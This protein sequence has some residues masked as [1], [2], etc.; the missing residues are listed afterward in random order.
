MGA[1]HDSTKTEGVNQEEGMVQTRR[2]SRSMA[3]LG[4]RRASV[5]V[6][7]VGSGVGDP[8]LVV[9]EG[10]AMTGDWSHLSRGDSDWLLA[11]IEPHVS[12]AIRASL[13]GLSTEALS[14]PSRPLTVR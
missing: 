9:G 4:V 13:N 14:D 1:L 10:G 8:L 7:S 5:P 3:A 2:P 6:R 11:T 12:I